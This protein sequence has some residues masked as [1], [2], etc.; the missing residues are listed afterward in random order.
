[1]NLDKLLKKVKHLNEKCF[2]D[3][4]L[5]HNLTHM[6]TEIDEVISKPDDL[7]EY[8]DLLI[9]FMGAFGKSGFSLKQLEEAC[10]QKIIKNL[11]REWAKQP[12]GT[13]KH[14]KK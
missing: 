1:M 7:E 6:K 14:I 3:A 9:C 2:P 5:E 8:S 10:K 12:N 4:K 11:G 13:Y